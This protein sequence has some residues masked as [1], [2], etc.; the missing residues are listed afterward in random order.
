M[1]LYCH[2][3]R[4]SIP[5]Q[6]IFPR[7]IKALFCI[8]CHSFFDGDYKRLVQSVPIPLYT[9]NGSDFKSKCPLIHVSYEQVVSNPEET[10][11]RLTDF[12]DVPYEPEALDYKR[13]KVAEGLGD[14][15]G[16]Q[17]HDRPVTSSKDKWVLELAA[18]KR[19]FEIVAKQLAGVTPEDLS[20]W[21]TPKDMLWTAMNEADPK[22]YKRRKQDGPNVLTRKLLIGSG[23]T[24]QN[25][26][27]VE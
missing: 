15:L 11:K 7:V 24:F 1:H 6:Y 25:R 21:G 16:V 27:M 12:L 13:A 3:S 26:P 20:E 14:P 22:L 17:K 10:L 2:F 4:R 23:G 5:I 8:L 9:R 18:D 19:K